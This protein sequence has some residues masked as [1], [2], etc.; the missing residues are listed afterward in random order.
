MEEIEFTSTEVDNAAI[1]QATL[2]SSEPYNFQANKEEDKGDLIKCS[3]TTE[4]GVTATHNNG[5]IVLDGRVEKVL[6]KTKK[7]PGK[8]HNKIIILKV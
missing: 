3:E 1:S 2:Y 5:P 7:F 6:P 4:E 8:F